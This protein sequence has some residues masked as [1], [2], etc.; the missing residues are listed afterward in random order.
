MMV[1]T[2]MLYQYWVGRKKGRKKERVEE[3]TIFRR[4]VRGECG[5]GG[6]RWSEGGE[7]WGDRIG[8]RWYWRW[9]E[10]DERDRAHDNRQN[11]NADWGGRE[12]GKLGGEA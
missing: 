5:G 3:G 1:M 6:K 2:M 4:L 10:M 7:K 8:K 12:G 9:V 11:T